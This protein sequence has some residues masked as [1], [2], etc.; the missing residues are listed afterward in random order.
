[1]VVKNDRKLPLNLR[2][3]D[4]RV[5]R[6]WS[7]QE[8]ADQVGTTPVNISRWENGLTFPSPYYRQRLCEVFG[9]TLAELG[10]LPPPTDSRV[11]DVPITRNPYFTGR[12]PLLALLHNRLS[13]AR[14]AAL[15]QPQTLYRLGGIG[16]HSKDFAE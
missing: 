4:A 7:Q 6:A 10:L 16:I 1:V 3:H 13:T 15:T 11:G 8:L 9:N 5:E 14:T 2:L 12:E